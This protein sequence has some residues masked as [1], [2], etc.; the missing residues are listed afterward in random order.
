MI[1]LWDH[2]RTRGLSLTET[3]LCGSWL[4]T[5]LPVRTE[6]HRR[7]NLPET[8][9]KKPHCNHNCRPF[10][11]QPADITHTAINRRSKHD[12]SRGK[13]RRKHALYPMHECSHMRQQDVRTSLATSCGILF[14]WGNASNVL[15]QHNPVDLWQNYS[16][17]YNKP[18]LTVAKSNRNHYGC[19]PQLRKA[20]SSNRSHTNIVLYWRLRTEVL[21]AVRFNL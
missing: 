14:M 6:G 7:V 20:S 17:T 5:N 9:R 8:K 21:G 18:T 19:K 11:S 3:S 12:G 2:R 16:N 13:S 10:I 1:I 4:Y 15:P